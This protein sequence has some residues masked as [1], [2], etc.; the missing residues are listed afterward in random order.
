MRTPH[1]LWGLLTVA[2]VAW[3]L[4]ITGYV[5]VKGAWDI[6]NM[7]RRLGGG[8]DDRPPEP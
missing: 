7:L 8:A 3:Y 4:L 5:A 1:L 2:A 6:R